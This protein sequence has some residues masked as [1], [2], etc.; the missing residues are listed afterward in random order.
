MGK[1]L[2]PNNKKPVKKMFDNNKK[3]NMMKPDNITVDEVSSGVK[4]NNFEEK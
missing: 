3:K 1:K 4:I 2:K